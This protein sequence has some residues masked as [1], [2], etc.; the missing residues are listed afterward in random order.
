MGN[1]RAPAREYVK[2][3][4]FA[5]FGLLCV[6]LGGG[7]LAAGGPPF[8][9]LMVVFFGLFMV[10]A[11][12]LFVPV[13]R[14][15]VPVLRHFELDGVSAPA[16]VFDYSGRRLFIQGTALVLLAAVGAS[17]IGAWAAGETGASLGVCGAVTVLLFGSFA[18]LI[19][20]RA[21]HAHYVALTPDAVRIVEP[22][23]R[24]TVPWDAISELGMVN[25]NDQLLIGLKL[26]PGA[27]LGRGRGGRW[28]RRLNRLYGGDLFIAAGSLTCPPEMLFWA[29][30]TYGGFPERRE[31]LRR[32]TVTGLDVDRRL[33]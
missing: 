14:E 17:A 21:R 33:P 2:P 8:V 25:A 6:L 24:F 23:Y 3:G 26:A 29:L 4:L 11:A 12:M 20:A 10:V 31:D 1:R 7:G 27:K 22:A 28:L 9:L 30:D 13:R 32:G 15:A 19:A 16:V 18:I 5:A